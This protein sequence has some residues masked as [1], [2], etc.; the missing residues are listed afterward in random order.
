MAK[1]D[2]TQIFATGRLAKGNFGTPKKP[3]KTKPK[4][5]KELAKTRLGKGAAKKTNPTASIVGNVAKYLTAK[6]NKKESQAAQVK[7]LAAVKRLKK[8]K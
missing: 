3:A 1:K 5:D 8:K 7:R 6:K 2:L 4:T